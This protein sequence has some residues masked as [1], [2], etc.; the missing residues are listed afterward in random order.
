[1]FYWW[2]LCMTLELRMSLSLNLLSNLLFADF[3]LCLLKAYDL[4]K[5]LLNVFKHFFLLCLSAWHLH[6]QTDRLFNNLICKT[7]GPRPFLERTHLGVKV[8]MVYLDALLV[9]VRF[10]GEILQAVFK[11]GVSLR[12]RVVFKVVDCACC[13]VNF[14]IWDSTRTFLTCN[15]E[16]KVAIG[17]R[18]VNEGLSIKLYEVITFSDWCH[19]IN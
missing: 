13:R 1:M 7:K 6:E 8:C 14:T 11:L 17:G 10:T 3:K 16:E 2:L 15:V 5:D 19:W 18:A 4:V 9:T 12:R